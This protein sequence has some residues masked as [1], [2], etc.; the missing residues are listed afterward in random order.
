MSNSNI[1]EKDRLALP[2]YSNSI[3]FFHQIT[4]GLISPWNKSI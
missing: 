4:A 1:P 3:S 2:L